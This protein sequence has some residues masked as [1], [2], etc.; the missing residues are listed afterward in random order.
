[1]ERSMKVLNTL[2]GISFLFSLYFSLDGVSTIYTI[3]KSATTFLILL[4]P[5][6]ST[7]KE[8]TFSIKGVVL[9]LLFCLMG[10]ILILKESLFVFA[11]GSFLIGHLVFSVVLIQKCGFQR[12][13]FVLFPL[14][15]IAIVLFIS[16]RSG[17]G[18]IKIPVIFYIG[19][20][21]FMCWQALSVHLQFKNKASMWFALGA[22]LF[23][24][25]DSVLG[26]NKFVGTFSYSSVLILSTYWGGIYGISR[27]THFK[28]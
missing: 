10:D 11:L 12:N 27:A 1:M 7:L 23:L 22:L 18:A 25:S 26:I 6:F 15:F 5:F 2:I 20:I 8:E 19:C 24:I 17:L 4:L 3:S 28:I 21:V 13:L 14:L 16:M 9:G